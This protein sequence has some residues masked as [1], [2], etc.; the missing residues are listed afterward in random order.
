VCEHAGEEKETRS[1]WGA[2][3]P[4]I[5]TAIPHTPHAYAQ[6]PEPDPCTASCIS[7]SA[8]GILA[9]H[10]DNHH[11]SVAV[12]QAPADGTE[13][14]N[15]TEL[16][17]APA[18]SAGERGESK[19]EA[20]QAPADV[21]VAAAEAEAQVRPPRLKHRDRMRYSSVTR[22]SWVMLPV[23]GKLLH[24]AP[25]RYALAWSSLT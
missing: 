3:D 8:T 19:V 22:S 2:Q 25:H 17:K 16:S 12:D 14:N 21:P 1:A 5:I 15:I 7:I 9:Q 10:D 18:A 13:H 24:F 23:R 4:A 20:A 11:S 6:Q